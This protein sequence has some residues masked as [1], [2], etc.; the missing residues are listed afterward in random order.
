ML[1]AYL[2]EH[3]A[4]KVVDQ[5]RQNRCAAHVKGI[6]GDRLVKNIDIPACRE[7]AKH[8]RGQGA[9][10]ST[11]RRELNVLPAAANHAK[12]WKRLS[13]DDLPQIELPEVPESEKV[14]WL[15]KEQVRKL[16]DA[17][18]FDSVNGAAVR[19]L[20]YTA[21]RVR[22]VERLEKYQV[23]LDNSLIH[24]AKKGE[25][26][27][28]KR[29]PTVPLYDEIRPSVEWLYGNDWRSD[30]LFGKKI[31]LQRRFVWLCQRVGID[32]HPHML[33]HSRAT[34]MLMDGVS[35]YGVSKLL[36]DTVATVERV[37]GHFSPEFLKHRS[38]V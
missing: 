37:Y 22:S 38:G 14:K 36:G 2:A 27:T 16:F 24:L 3:V 5:E 30:W 13:I 33:R 15:T 19:I 4:E 1:D 29:R 11:I 31:S 6:L 8:R 25:R 20:Y 21:G 17:E 7:Y 9:A 26:K 34:H 10:E 12:R 18:P 23:D 35:I 28:K 32:A